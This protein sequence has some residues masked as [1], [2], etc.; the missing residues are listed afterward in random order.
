ME[1]CLAFWLRD[2][3]KAKHLPSLVFG[4]RLE[5]SKLNAKTA[6]DKTCARVYRTFIR[7]GLILS[8]QEIFYPIRSES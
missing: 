6:L 4:L 1:R 3:Q 8:K 2:G 7:I 5:G